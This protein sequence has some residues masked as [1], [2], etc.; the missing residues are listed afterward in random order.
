MRFDLDGGMTRN[1]S[2]DAG[3]FG[4]ARHATR[5]IAQLVAV[6]SIAVAAPRAARAESPRIHVHGGSRITA[7]AARSPGAVVVS[8]TFQDDAGDPIATEPLLVTLERGT[9]AQAVRFGAEETPTG[10]A[11][12][13]PPTQVE[14][15][16]TAVL[17]VDEAG[18][19][20]VRIPLPV[21]H[22]VVHLT[23]RATPLLDPAK[24]DVTIDLTRR[25][26][27]LALDPEPH[28]VHLDDDAL[29]IQAVASADDEGAAAPN[30]M[31]AITNE[32]GTPLGTATTNSSG[33]A[34]FEI[35]MDR[36][37]PPGTG[38]LRVAFQG[39]ADVTAAT[40]AVQI[41]RRARVH[42]ALAAAPRG[43]APDEGIGLDVLA[44]T[45]A[46]DLHGGTIEARLGD[47]VV[48]AG[49]VEAG[50]AHVVATFVPP[51]AAS[52]SL[53]LQYLPDAPWFEVGEPLVVSVPV[54]APSPWRQLPLVLA[55]IAVAAFVVLGRVGA[56]TRTIVPPRPVRP[57]A[58][59]PRIDLVRPAAAG[60]NR[61]T[62]RAVDAHDGSPLVHAR[63]AIER[64]GFG[65]VEI[66]ATAFTDESGGFDLAP[67]EPITEGA[68]VAEGPLHRELRQKLPPPGE[69]VLS[70]VSR[71]RALLGSLVEWARARGRP[72]DARP[73]ATPGHVRR[74]A[75]TDVRA[76]RWAEAVERAAFG[77]A[78][79][80][81]RMEQDV[82]RLAPT[83][84]GDIDGAP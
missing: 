6:A 67:P 75:E 70:L 37:G 29:S 53:V 56:K 8:G 40:H 48:G 32:L 18:R 63:I 66:A 54:N 21:D 28:V 5:R 68:L 13:A 52:A 79:V 22:Y 77:L 20:C 34:R 59:E 9:G 10:C 14:G 50:R 73:E 7:H 4:A 74:V 65:R 25:S 36:M 76:S 2:L 44:T 30:L 81:A 45:R 82:D 11:L 49:T 38:E 35:P 60:V 17:V 1:F 27:A 3:A 43:G 71:R 64:P 33:R 62:G 12:H 58:P 78:D 55:G 80:D 72:Y 69:V 24:L 84:R 31:L 61:W 19:F 39:D 42:L 15:E 57:A 16:T 41:E 46:G 51:P 23:S 83:A 26:L 47:A